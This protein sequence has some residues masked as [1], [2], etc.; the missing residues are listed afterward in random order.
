MTASTTSTPKR[1][2]TTSPIIISP[3]FDSPSPVIP[4]AS[5]TSS[6]SI[7]QLEISVPTEEARI[8]DQQSYQDQEYEQHADPA[9]NINHD[10]KVD[11]DA[12][13][14]NA[15]ARTNA[16]C[17]RVSKLGMGIGPSLPAPLLSSVH[18]CNAT[19]LNLHANELRHLHVVSRHLNEKGNNCCEGFGAFEALAELDV[20]SNQLGEGRRIQNTALKQTKEESRKKCANANANAKPT[21]HLPH[22]FDRGNS[23]TNANHIAPPPSANLLDMLPNLQ[24]LNLSANNLTCASLSHLFLNSSNHSNNHRKHNANVTLPNLIRLDLSHNRLTKLS[25]NV[26]HSCP[27]LQHLS[28]LNNRFTSIYNLCAPFQESACVDRMNTNSTPANSCIIE[29]STLTHLFLQDCNST[30]PT[31]DTQ[32]TICHTRGYRSKILRFFPSLVILDGLEVDEAMDTDNELGMNLGLVQ[33]EDHSKND[34][35]NDNRDTDHRTMEGRSDSNI[36]YNSSG[37]MR[38]L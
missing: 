7:S 26:I 11:I 27:S 8:D 14:T 38:R 9:V 16:N 21:H 1:G 2:I 32:N 36:M 15:I 17:K 22:H 3:S 13:I 28:L 20:S 23:I 35:V 37:R 19:H 34:M 25:S 33:D 24:Y 5:A 18:Q 30:T 4:P 10:R 6:S 12:A 29:T 31:R